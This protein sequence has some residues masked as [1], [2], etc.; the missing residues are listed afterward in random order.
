MELNFE[1]V[2]KCGNELHQQIEPKGYGKNVVICLIIMFTLRVMVFK[3]SITAHFLYFLLIT[4][5]N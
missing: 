3:M 5:K 2:F 1:G 4:A